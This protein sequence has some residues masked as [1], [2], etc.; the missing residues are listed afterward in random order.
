MRNMRNMIM[1]IMITFCFTASICMVIPINSAST[2][3]YNA[4]SDI[5]HDGAV[6]LSDLVLMANSYGTS[7]DP[8]L[9]VTVMN[10]PSIEP[11]PSYCIQQYALNI[12]GPGVWTSPVIYCGGYSEISILFGT[13]F[14]NVSQALSQSAAVTV[15]VQSISW[16]SNSTIPPTGLDNS[17]E[18]LSSNPCNA[19]YYFNGTTI[20]QYAYDTETFGPYFQLNFFPTISCLSSPWF[21]DFHYSVYMRN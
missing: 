9:N 6:N 13:A 12:T 21:I 4:F 18:A 2:K 1:A 3:T 10:Q 16:Y 8:T 14:Y 5:N 17:N 20:I 19:V 15:N 11:T 7:G